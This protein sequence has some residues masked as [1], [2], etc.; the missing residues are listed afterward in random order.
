MK[1]PDS[2]R[3][4]ALGR[5]GGGCL[6]HGGLKGLEKES[7]RVNPDGSLALTPHPERLGSTL[8][9]PYITTDYSE[10]LL[11]FI[12][13][14][15]PE[16]SET[17]AFL[18]EVQRFT[19]ANI[20][21]EMLWA[22]SMP[23]RL[24][25][26]EDIP[27][28]LYGRSNIGHMKHVYRRGLGHRYGRRMQTISGV[29][30]NYSLPRDF[31]PA[32]KELFGLDLPLPAVRNKAY[33]GLIRNFHRLGWLVPYLFGASPAI[34]SSFLEPGMED[35]LPGAMNQD[36]HTVYLP[37]A[38]SLRMSDIG[39]RNKA[40]QA[41][42]GISYDN[43]DAYVASLTHAIETPW[44]P[45][46]RIGVKVDGEYRQLNDHILQIENEYYSFI[47][48][49]QLA[50]SGE[51]PTRALQRGGVEYIEVRALDV[52]AFDPL[53]VNLPELHFLEVF[54][55]LCLLSDSPL[56]DADEQAHIDHNQTLVAIRG[57]EPGL[58]L[59]RAGGEV[60]LS[61]WALEVLDAMTPIAELLDECEGDRRYRDTLD[62]Q[63]EVA[64]H[65]ETAPS[66]RM[67]DEMRANNES[68]FEFALRKSEEHRRDALAR[69]LD[70]ARAAFFREAASKS[71]ADQRAIEEADE[72]SFDEFLARYFAQTL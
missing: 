65:P 39:Y 17:L 21:D 60:A 25:N 53:G 8:T 66:A 12:T 3:I 54:L 11:E 16:A 62:R 7:L 13:P 14:P 63:R 27:I 49:K 10:A 50:R 30:F 59:Q 48:P 69:P 47:R 57:R 42:L 9:H 44:E 46:T 37:W 70:E 26:D 68:F 33:F 1:Y 52:S 20:D 18:D 41:A 64:R 32:W 40:A 29:H 71:L 61:D 22:A 6:F 55:A 56:I 28:A 4:D 35:L 67:L 31:W 15:T 34:C 5:T 38:T 58:R 43:L 23:C 36:G 19:Y 45:Y 51:K 72:L 2:A 24:G